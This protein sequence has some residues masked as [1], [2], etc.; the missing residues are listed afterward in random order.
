MTEI[1]RRALS[2]A[3]V[4]FAVDQD[5]GTFTGYAAVFNDLVPSYNERV[6]PGAFKRTLA[7]RAARG[8]KLAILWAHDP[9]EVIGVATSLVEDSFG[10]RVEGRLILDIAR[11][12]EAYTLIQEGVNSLS[13]GFWPVKWTRN[14]EGEYLIE[15]A[16]LVEFSVVYA[17]ASPRAKILDIRQGVTMP[18]ANPT[19]E[20]PAIET[21]TLKTVPELDSSAFETRLTELQTRLDEFE[22][23]SQR[24]PAAP[25]NENE[26]AE[27]ESRALS[28]LIR[29]GSEAEIR[30]AGSDVGPDGGWI[31]LPTIDT[32]IRSLMTDLSP[33]R[34]LAEVVT[35]S[36]DTYERFYSLGKRGAQRVSQ[37]DDRPQDTARPELIKHSYG[38]GEYYAAPAATRHLLDDASIDVASWLLNNASQDFAETEGEDFLS[39]DGTDGFPRG[40]LD[41]GTAN[42]KDFVRPW[43]KHQYIP[44]GHASAPTDAN[45]VTACINIVAALR[46]PYKSNA[47]WLMNSTTASRLMGINDENGR[48]LWAPTGNLIEGVEHPLLGYRVELDD[49]MPDLAEGAGAHPIAFGDFRQGYVIVDRHGVRVERD[50]VTQKG[51]VI[52]DT[53]KRVGGGAGDF[54]AIKFI[55][56]AAS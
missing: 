24:V 8:D 33:M 12:S 6:L 32:R 53:Y 30:A 39:Y 7:E 55:K 47:T 31:V 2:P 28:H 36:G 52:F 27:L 17:G 41:Y 44:A 22:V 14:D 51:R 38:V 40:L 5:A 48:R 46:K 1:S 29:T 26:Q 54:N 18:E 9:R 50:A 21:H 25:R 3:Q 4:R 15:D 34:S 56:I 11:A 16:E 13:I 20:N 43:G 35:I 37:R 10:L 49:N 23:R 45:L 42:T 19:P